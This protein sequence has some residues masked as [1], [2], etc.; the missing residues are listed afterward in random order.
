MKKTY[1]LPGF[2]LI[3]LI[4]VI[5]IIGLLFT[6]GL[7]SYNNFNRKQLLTQSANT[8]KN[9]LRFI[10]SKAMSGEKDAVC[11]TSSLESWLL[12]VTSVSPQSSYMLQGRC[13][14]GVSFGYKQIWLPQGIKIDYP[15]V[16]TGFIRFK[17]LALG[18][19]GTDPVNPHITISD[20]SNNTKTISVNPSGQ[21]E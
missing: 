5:A 15:P 21:I 7:A 19:D 20:D 11:G 10:Q 16:T 2:T 6:L 18:A 12:I 9:D 3:E 14:N 4:V 1:L 8:I 13:T 17:P